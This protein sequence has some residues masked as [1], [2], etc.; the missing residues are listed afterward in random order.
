[1]LRDP[2]VTQILCTHTVGFRLSERT[3]TSGGEC[4]SEQVGTQ[5]YLARKLAELLDSRYDTSAAVSPPDEINPG[6][7]K[8]GT[9]HEGGI[10]LLSTSE[11]P[12]A[13]KEESNST[14]ISRRVHMDKDVPEGVHLDKDVP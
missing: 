9:I 5:T 13:V 7:T 11:Q 4:A 12:I 1:M 2:S 3:P 14:I 8:P 10:R 6:T